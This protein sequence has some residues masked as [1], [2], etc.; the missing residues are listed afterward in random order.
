[1]ELSQENGDPLDWYD[2]EASEFHIAQTWFF[3]LL[4]SQVK[5]ML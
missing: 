5:D 2:G 4:A 3:D 1:M